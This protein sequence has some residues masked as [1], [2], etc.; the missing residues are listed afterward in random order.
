MSRSRRPEDLS[1]VELNPDKPGV[2]EYSPY[3]QRELSY[4]NGSFS[5]VKDSYDVSITPTTAVEDN[6][7]SQVLLPLVRGNNAHVT[8]R[9]R[10]FIP[11]I[12]LWL[13]A[14]LPALMGALFY[15]SLGFEASHGTF[16][17]NGTYVRPL[18]EG[19]MFGDE[20]SFLSTHFSPLLLSSISS[21]LIGVLSPAVMGLTGYHLAL[22][23]LRSSATRS[24][25]NPTP[26]QYYHTLDLVSNASPMAYLRLLIY[27]T[28]QGWSRWKSTRR[29]HLRISKMLLVAGGAMFTILT[30]D[31]AIRIIDVVLH[32]QI[33]STIMVTPNDIP[34][35]FPANA[36]IKAG[37][38]DPIVNVCG[39]VNRTNEASL[40][41]LN[42]S[43][44]F[45][46][47]E[48]GSD[49]LD[50][51]DSIAFIGPV[52]PPS[53]LKIEARTLVASTHCEVYHPE[54]YVKDES[55]RV[56]GP[57]LSSNLTETPELD[58]WNQLAWTAGFN[59]T[60]WQ[61]RLQAYI[62]VKG[63]LT[64][65]GANPPYSLSSG[66]NA[67]PFTTASFGCFPNY[68]NIPYSDTNM[69]YQ[70]PFINWW[71]YGAG[72][73]NK[74]YQLC[75]VSLCNTTVYDARYKLSNGRLTL[76][77]SSLTLANAS[78]AVAVSGAGMF[79]GTDDTLFYQWGPRFIDD[80]MQID[81]SNA[82]NTYGNS[83]S[84]FSAAWAQAFSNRYL[85]WSAGMVELADHPAELFRQQ[86]ALSIPVATTYLFTVL[87]FV[88]ALGIFLLG[89]SCLVVA[90]GDGS[91]RTDLDASV[92]R[93]ADTSTLVKEL[94]AK[95]L[96]DQ[97]ME[98]GKMGGRFAPGQSD[99]A[100]DPGTLYADS[101]VSV[102]LRRRADGTLGLGFRREI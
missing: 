80:Q 35:T 38:E 23:W 101:E 78:A 11:I 96:H 74:P 67:N 8:S 26:M 42:Q 53:N 66:S 89:I 79:L 57:T 70:T 24:G 36:V 17:P 5:S 43:T 18:N 32:S 14:L 95:S 27:V 47:Y 54:C 39:V 76:D 75:S 30:L 90:R 52:D 34:M 41:G 49:D 86:L 48:H 84:Q 87:H 50:R 63:N 29:R 85:G 13:S 91:F 1:L 19:I 68:G 99:L 82:G 98:D 31:L 81:L 45:R 2:G 72:I 40:G 77:N 59:T 3:F 16:Y 33:V 25:R 9:K 71:T 69:S 37:C 61:M 21:S 4:S 10:I 12:I 28:K 56:C 60:D 100:G 64:V 93:L 7:K 102:G 73:G 44:V 55:P 22:Y 97:E 58:S 65:P 83:T 51:Q 92:Q 88:Y 6:S 15:A 94:A 46:V 62:T 20:R